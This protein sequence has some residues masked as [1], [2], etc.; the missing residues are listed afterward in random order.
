MFDGGPNL[1]LRDVDGVISEINV[2][3]KTRWSGEYIKGL[4]ESWATMDTF[5]EGVNYAC[6]Y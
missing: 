4:K 6:D 5:G 3:N 1:I 2:D